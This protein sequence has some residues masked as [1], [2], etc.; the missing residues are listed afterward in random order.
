MDAVDDGVF[1]LDG[2]AVVDFV[3]V[4][5]SEGDTSPVAD[6]IRVA[7]AVDVFVDDAVAVPVLAALVVELAVADFV[8]TALAVPVADAVAV[9]VPVVDSD[10]VALVFAEP[11]TCAFDGVT[12]MVTRAGEGVCVD[13]SPVAVAPIDTEDERAGDA[14]E[15]MDAEPVEETVSARFVAVHDGVAGFVMRNDFDGVGVTVERDVGSASSAS[16]SPRKARPSSGAVVTEK[17]GEPA[18]VPSP[19]Q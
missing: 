10:I 17:M 8:N 14:D 18:K 16:A 12:E 1:E 9:R 15:L 5:D 4:V 6:A 3:D 2:V 19:V 7:A 11:V 13:S